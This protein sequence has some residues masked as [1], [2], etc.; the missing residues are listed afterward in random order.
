M[1]Y[2]QFIRKKLSYFAFH[3]SLSYAFCRNISLTPQRRRNYPK[4]QHCKIAHN[5]QRHVYTW[6]CQKRAMF[7][8]GVFWGNL[9]NLYFVDPT[10]YT[11][12]GSCRQ[13]NTKHAPT[14]MQKTHIHI[15]PHT[16]HHSYNY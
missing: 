11:R 12:K 3:I 9:K 15:Q 6:R 8:I 5:W 7:T 4:D 1:T 10:E 2:N 13:R 14:S 16:L